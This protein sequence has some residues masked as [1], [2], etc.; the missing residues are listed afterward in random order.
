[1][2]SW[3]GEELLLL[4]SA[5]GPEGRVCSRARAGG[6]AAFPGQESWVGQK[7]TAPAVPS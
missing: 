2:F 4:L 6:E 5:V 1:M 3:T 7:K